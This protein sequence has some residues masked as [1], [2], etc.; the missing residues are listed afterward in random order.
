L[1]FDSAFPFGAGLGVCAA[2]GVEVVPVDVV[3]GGVVLDG[4]VPVVVPV[5]P[6]APAIPAA[7]PPVTSAPAT[8]VAPSIF[9]MRIGLILSVDGSGDYATHHAWRS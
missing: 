6:E 7:A 5:A 9:E 4:A 1:G 3:P 8:I 2:P